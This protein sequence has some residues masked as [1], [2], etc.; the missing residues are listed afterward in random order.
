MPKGLSIIAAH[1][2]GLSL[3]IAPTL[4]V[5]FASLFIAF[6]MISIPNLCVAYARSPVKIHVYS[7]RLPNMLASY[8]E[9]GVKTISFGL[10]LR[11]DTTYLALRL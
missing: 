1:A 3:D 8:Q 10:R 9:I 5:R 11:P 2:L 6:A 4:T 7:M